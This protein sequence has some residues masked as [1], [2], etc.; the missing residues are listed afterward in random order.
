MQTWFKLIPALG[1]LT[2]VVTALVLSA[3]T[4][5]YA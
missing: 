2:L 4:S 3:R 5:L 1:A